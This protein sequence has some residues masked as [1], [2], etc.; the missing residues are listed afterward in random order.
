MRL[1]RIK[2]GVSDN[3]FHLD[4]RGSHSHRLTSVEVVLFLLEDAPSLT[5][6]HPDDRYVYCTVLTTHGPRVVNVDALVDL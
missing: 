1:L 4:G 2:K 3:A 6:G 5:A